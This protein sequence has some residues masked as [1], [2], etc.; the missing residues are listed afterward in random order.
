MSAYTPKTIINFLSKY[1]K[2]DLEIILTVVSWGF[3]K[4]LL[5]VTCVRGLRVARRTERKLL[6]ERHTSLDSEDRDKTRG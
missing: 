1:M 5:C 6:F 3:E 4:S 2:K